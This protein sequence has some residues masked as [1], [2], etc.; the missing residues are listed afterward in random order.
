MEPEVQ[1]VISI[2]DSHFRA[3][4]LSSVGELCEN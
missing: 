4:G 2:S 3:F 1:L